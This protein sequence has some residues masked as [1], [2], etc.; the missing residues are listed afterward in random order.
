LR[1]K[2]QYLKN[3]GSDLKIETV[4]D[5]RIAGELLEVNSEDITIN[6]KVKAKVKGSRK[7]KTD[8]Q[9]TTLRFEDIKSAKVN[10]HFKG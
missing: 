4:D 1:V 6:A 5:K 9:S 7:S 10:L 8:Y 3:I 2:Q